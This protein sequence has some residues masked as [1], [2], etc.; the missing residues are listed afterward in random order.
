MVVAADDRPL[1]RTSVL[2]PLRASSGR[3]PP[4]GQRPFA[5]GK[6]PILYAP[7][8]PRVPKSSGSSM[9]I[10][11]AA[12][13]RRRCLGFASAPP[14]YVI[15]AG[16]VIRCSKGGSLP[17]SPPRLQI[18]HSHG[19]RADEEFYLNCGARWCRWFLQ[20]QLRISKMPAHRPFW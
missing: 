11:P 13:G 3:G 9:P 5:A 17:G 20:R 7:P 16:V 18:W 6:A 19:R 10:A 1:L 15:L 2:L 14:V 4:A 12:C 8:D